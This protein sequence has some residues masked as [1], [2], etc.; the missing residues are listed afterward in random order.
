MR[1]AIRDKALMLLDT[2][3]AGTFYSEITE[4]QCGAVILGIRLGKTIQDMF[5]AMAEDYQNG[6]SA[7][8][9]VEKY[10]IKEIFGVKE[11]VARTVV[12]NALGGYDGNFISSKHEAYPGLIE[13]KEEFKR[14]AKRHNA[15]SGR[16]AGLKQFKLKKGIHAQTPRDRLELGSFITIA[17]GRVPYTEEEFLYIYK[18]AHTPEFKMGIRIKASKVAKAV[19]NKFHKGEEVR[20]SDKITKAFMRI[21]RYIEQGVLTVE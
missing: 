10:K 3:P 14:L 11:G 20:N 6:L 21:K 8:Q 19:N 13:D 4:K 5:P 2:I 16:E 1:V 18:L 17:K 12:Y 9:I 7:R 15:E